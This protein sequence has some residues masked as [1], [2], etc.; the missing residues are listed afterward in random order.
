MPKLCLWSSLDVGGLGGVGCLSSSGLANR[1][2]LLKRELSLSRG[3]LHT[4]QVNECP[5]V[6]VK[7]KL[8]GHAR[9]LI[10]PTFPGASEA[11]G[12]SSVSSTP[13]IRP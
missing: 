12:S 11:P 4:D 9:F 5:V 7:G 3:V 2:N 1:V 10:P 6:G 13:T 8:T